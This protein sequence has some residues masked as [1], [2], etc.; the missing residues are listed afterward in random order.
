[1]TMRT[2]GGEIM[3]IKP[4]ETVY[5][6]YRFRSRLE[7]RWA[8]FFDKAG[9][10]YEY[11]LDGFI[12]KN[13][14]RYLPDFFLPQFD[15]FVEIK[16]NP[17][18]DDYKWLH[19]AFEY[20]RLNQDKVNGI[21]CCYGDPMNNNIHYMTECLA[22]P[23]DNHKGFYEDDCCFKCRDSDKEPFLI[24]NNTLDPT[25]VFGPTKNAWRII[26]NPDIYSNYEAEKRFAR[27]AR[28]EYGETPKVRR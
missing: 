11:E 22:S 2:K 4:I 15:I 18:I 1:M 13:G 19:F 6:G 5:N 24:M 26:G 14:T 8:V 25:T 16:A 23:N 27:Q 21:I 3:D 28:F 9:I 10:E 7:A 12:L 20:T 17:D